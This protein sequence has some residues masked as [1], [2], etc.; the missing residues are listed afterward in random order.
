MRIASTLARRLLASGSLAL[1]VA[2]PIAA[3]AALLPEDSSFG[4][5]TIT[6][7]TDTGLRWLDLTESAGLGY[8]DAAQELL[9]GG[10]FEG[11][12]MATEAEVA[13]FFTN[14][15]LDTSTNDFESDNHAPAVGLAALV[16]QLGSNGNCGVG[17][18]FDFSAGFYA[19]SPPQG[20]VSVASIAWFDNSAGLDPSSPQT[21]VGRAILEGYNDG[22]PNPSYGTWLVQAPEPGAVFLTFTG[23]ASLAAFRT[24]RPSRR[25]ASRSAISA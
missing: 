4:P 21:P 1:A 11:Y 23:V 6:Y 14:A 18:S 25:R 8:A 9:P 20:F 22:G 10:A 24:S 12:R 7:D 13:A 15:G 2:A 19:G 5:D 3:G 17:C 16:G